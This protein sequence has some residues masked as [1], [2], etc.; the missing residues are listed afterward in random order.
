MGYLRT[1]TQFPLSFSVDATADN[2]I[3]IA[4]RE[5]VCAA[6]SRETTSSFASFLWAQTARDLLLEELWTIK[7]LSSVTPAAVIKIPF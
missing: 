7:V 4:S 5:R 3:M 1:G 6:I 2:H